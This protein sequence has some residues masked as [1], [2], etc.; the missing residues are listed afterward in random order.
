MKPSW[1]YIAS[2]AFVL[3][4]ATAHADEAKTGA[5]AAQKPA[6]KP[7]ITNPDWISLPSGEQL[8]AYYPDLAQ[9]LELGGQA[10]MSCTVTATGALT[11]CSV[12]SEAPAGVGFGQ[13]ALGMSK[14]FQMRPLA[15]DGHPVGGGQEPGRPG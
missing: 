11:N 3:A 1:A 8:D 6:G 10:T 13:A 14:L 7:T 9:I 12:A 4:A 5:T 15:V 2:I